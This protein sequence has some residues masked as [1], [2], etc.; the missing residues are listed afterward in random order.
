MTSFKVQHALSSHGEPQAY[1]Q[2]GEDLVMHFQQMSIEA[3]T[4]TICPFA[5][6]HEDRASLEESLL[7]IREENGTVG[8]WQ[9]FEQLGAN[10]E[11][12]EVANHA[13]LLSA[14]AKQAQHLLHRWWRSLALPRRVHLRKHFGSCQEM[15]CKQWHRRA[16]SPLLCGQSFTTATAPSPLSK[17]GVCWPEKKSTSLTVS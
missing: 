2:R 1:K 5:E 8:T 6:Q 14:A 10:L 11:E 16:E 17:Q 15:R 3:S 9:K 7:M 12:G 13:V 4:F